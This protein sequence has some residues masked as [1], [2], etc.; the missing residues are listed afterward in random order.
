[1]QERIKKILE[2]S[3]LNQQDFANRIA[4]SPASLTNILKGRSNATLP[5]VMSIRASF[6]EV[7]FSWLLDGK[8]E[9]LLTNP[10][11]QESGTSETSEVRQGDLFNNVAAAGTVKPVA[12]VSAPLSVSDAEVNTP[13][14]ASPSAQPCAPVQI[15]KYVDKPVRR[16]REIQVFYDD[17]TY[18]VFVP[19]K[20]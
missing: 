16:V 11:A 8:G 14:P 10:P 19:R 7:N 9:M 6:P 1:M 17:D 18:E 5:I 13:L 15:I 2:Y 20:G 12:N 4:I 3:G